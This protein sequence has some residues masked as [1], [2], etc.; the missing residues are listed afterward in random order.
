MLFHYFGDI[1][2]LDLRIES[3]FRVDDDD[4]AEFAHSVA[5]GGDDQDFLVEVLLLQLF[6]EGFEYLRR[7]SR[8]AA[9]PVADENVCSV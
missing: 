8:S 5:A 6:P 1:L 3:S 7:S 9:C 2:G 4:G